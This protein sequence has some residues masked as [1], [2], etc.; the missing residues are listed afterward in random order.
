MREHRELNEQDRFT[1]IM[2]LSSEEG[3]VWWSV[4]DSLAN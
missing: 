4:G 3:S 1:C 2:H